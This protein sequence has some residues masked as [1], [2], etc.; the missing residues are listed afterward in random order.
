MLRVLL[1]GAHSTVGSYLLKQLLTRGDEVTVLADP[2]YI[3][4]IRYRDRLT[5][6]ANERNDAQMYSEAAGRQDVVI[7]L[8]GMVDVPGSAPIDPFEQ[9]LERL[10]LLIQA[11]A[12]SS[13]RLVYASTVTVYQPTPRPAMWPIAEDTPRQ[14]HG[15]DHLLHYGQLRIDAED[16]IQQYHNSHELEYVILRPT[17]VYAPHVW[18]VEGLLRQLVNRPRRALRQASALGTMQWVHASDAAEAFVLAAT[19]EEAANEIFNIAGGENVTMRGLLDTILR[20]LEE[21]SERNA[22]NSP[23]LQTPYRFDTSKARSLLGYKPRMKL[24]DGIKELLAT[25]EHKGQFAA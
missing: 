24:N 23:W 13:C 14:A 7:C 6:L 19:K 20:I 18:F 9:E 21:T 12:E 1:T 4:P 15:N 3:E 5:V 11:C 17:L 8:D 22:K 10:E 25:M 16:L 2:E